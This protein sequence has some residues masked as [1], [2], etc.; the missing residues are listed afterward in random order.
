MTRNETVKVAVRVRPLLEKEQKA[1]TI[2]FAV[3]E[4]QKQVTVSCPSRE[5]TLRMFSYDHIFGA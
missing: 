2:Q 5:G 1:G 4:G 3:A